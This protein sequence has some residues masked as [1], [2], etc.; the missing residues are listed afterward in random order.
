[1]FENMYLAWT[2]INWYELEDGK[3][4]NSVVFFLH[5]IWT[6]F[7][8]RSHFGTNLINNLTDS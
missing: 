1:M 8:Q 4:I 3:N 2:H 5:T 6:Y 7:N